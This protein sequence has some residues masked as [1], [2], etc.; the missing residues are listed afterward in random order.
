MGDVEENPRHHEQQE[1]AAQLGRLEAEHREQQVERQYHDHHGQNVH[2]ERD[3]GVAMALADV[4][5]RVVIDQFQNGDGR[6]EG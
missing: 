2:A 6:L 5:H 3:K 4:A 1:I